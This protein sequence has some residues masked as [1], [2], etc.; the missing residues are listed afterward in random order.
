M[1]SFSSSRAMHSDAHK[2]LPITVHERSEQDPSPVPTPLSGSRSVSSSASPFVSGTGS[3]NPH[4]GTDGSTRHSRAHPNH[5]SGASAL[6]PASDSSSPSSSP[7]SE[8]VSPSRTGPSSFTV[9]SW[10]H[11]YRGASP[12]E[13]VGAGSA[14]HA[15]ADEHH[16][17]HHHSQA[18]PSTPVIVSSYAQVFQSLPPFLSP[19]STPAHTRTNSATSSPHTTLPNSP[20][21]GSTHSHASALQHVR[22]LGHCFLKSSYRVVRRLSDSNDNKRT[23]VTNLFFNP[24]L[25]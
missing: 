24:S 22:F 19:I 1:N 20:H 14:G 18:P 3:V 7:P 17:H 8:L 25:S 4:D 23:M 16:R 2:L 6:A 21:L 15:H 13:S 10:P 9:L 12:V 5:S 11:A